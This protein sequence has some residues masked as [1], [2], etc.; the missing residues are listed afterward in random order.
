MNKIKILSVCL[1]I[2]LCVAAAC[3]FFKI[4]SKDDYRQ[5]TILAQEIHK[6]LEHLMF[7][8][9]DVGES[10]IQNVPA[11]GQWH[12]RIA[13]AHPGRDAGVEYQLR[14]G[15]LWRLNNGNAL[16]IADHIG[17]WRIRRQKATPDILEVQI[18]ARDNVSLLSNLKIKV[19]H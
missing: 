12:T 3:V 6:V 15:H 4:K 1:S 10:T 14:A 7:D 19:R 8:L 16:L 13:F 5:K 11:D 2:G 9:Y 17:A 18:E